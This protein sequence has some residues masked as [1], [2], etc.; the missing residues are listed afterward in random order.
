MYVIELSTH[1]VFISNLMCQRK[2][3][4]WRRFAEVVVDGVIRAKC[5]E[6]G[7]DIVT[8]HERM[9]STWIRARGQQPIEGPPPKTE[10]Q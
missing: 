6:W 10:K 1:F 3:G 7:N 5:D 4:V 8:N 2:R 9:Q